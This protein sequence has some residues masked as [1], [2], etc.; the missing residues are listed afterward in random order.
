MRL[1]KSIPQFALGALLTNAISMIESL[2]EGA[3]K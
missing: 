2:L 3:A 1:H